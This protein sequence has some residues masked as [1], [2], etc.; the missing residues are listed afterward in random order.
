MRLLHTADWHLGHTLHEYARQH[1]HDAFLRWLL[2]TAAQREVD[3]LIVAGD[4]FETG[5]P[6]AEAQRAFYSFLAQARKRL[7]HLGIVVIG[8]NHD[9]PAR[10]DAPDPVLQAFDVHVV[11]GL[12][13]AG[14]ELDL[15]RLIVPI[16]E[17]DGPG[18]II[19]AVPFLRMADLPVVNA[20]F[21]DPLVAGVRRL[22][23]QALDEAR[24]Q[25]KPRQ[26]LIATGHLYMTG[27]RTSDLSERKILGGNQHA[28]PAAMFPEDVAYVA[29]G[30]LHL[31]QSVGGREN[32]RYSGSPLPLSTAEATYPSQVALVQ[33]DDQKF[34]SMEAVRVPRLVD[35]IRVPADGPAAPDEVLPL[36]AALPYE[37][38][39]QPE[40]LRPFLDV[41]VRV[42]KPEPALRRAIEQIVARKAVRLVGL[43]FEA[44]PR[45]RS[46]AGPTTT[47][48]DLNP[49]QVFRRCYLRDHGTEPPPEI[50]E[51][52]HE[53]LQAMHDQ[54]EAA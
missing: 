42:D 9:S 21:D 34:T 54:A 45:R 15:E 12:P 2:D 6:P 46:L 22:Y 33:I 38:V 10:L 30:H 14:G 39:H 23:T 53:L 25:L 20:P 4:V 5:N 32:I 31:P 28:I 7:P 41:R 1:E 43:H 48:R 29:L 3:A 17:K 51:S 44:P 36:L 24:R 8:G 11:G 26:A 50:L 19:A 47:L 35:I 18:A 16:R 40:Y 27:G 13:R 52:F 37:D 49:E